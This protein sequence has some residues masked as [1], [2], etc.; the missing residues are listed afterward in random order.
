MRAHKE[1]SG[2]WSG[3]LFGMVT[4]MASLLSYQYLSGILREPRLISKAVFSEDERFENKETLAMFIAAENLRSAI[5]TL[6]AKSFCFMR[7]RIDFGFTLAKRLSGYTKAVAIIKP[8]IDSALVRAK[9]NLDALVSPR[10]SA[11]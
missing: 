6:L 9:S 11:L 4:G 10:A 5:Q 1:Q 3:A 2:F 7:L 8:V